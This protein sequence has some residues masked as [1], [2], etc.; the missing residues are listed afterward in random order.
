MAAWQIRGRW[1]RS[2]VLFAVLFALFIAAIFANRPE[3]PVAVAAPDIFKPDP[4][5]ELI[6]FPAPTRGIPGDRGDIR[7]PRGSVQVWMS[8]QDQTSPFRFEE[9]TAVAGVDFVHVSPHR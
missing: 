8:R 5:R 1:S 4:T 9:I 2:K 7:V 3:S 6:T